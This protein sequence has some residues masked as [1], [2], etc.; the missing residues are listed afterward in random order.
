M[1]AFHS[2]KFPSGEDEA[3]TDQI[4]ALSSAGTEVSVVSSR[5]P[6][7]EL[8]K[9]YEQIGLAWRVVTGLGSQE[10]PRVIESTRPD[11]IHIH[12][13]F[14]VWG[15][16][17]IRQLDTPALVTLHNY[18]NTCANGSLFRDGNKCELCIGGL[19]VDAV[20]F[21]CFKGSRTQSALIALGNLRRKISPFWVKE[22]LMTI[23]LSQRART[24]HLRA[25][26]PEANNRVLSNFLA[27]TE[28]VTPSASGR[29]GWVFAG[30]L[31][32]GKGI[33]DLID[34]WPDSEKLVI[35]GDGPERDKLEKFAEGKDVE[36]RG[37][38]AWQ[39]VEQ[40][41]LE[42]E[43]M[44]FPSLF[45]ENFPMVYLRALRTG[46][47]TVSIE[48]NTVADEIRDN[49]SGVVVRGLDKLTFGMKQLR[50]RNDWDIIC[51]EIFD[52]KYSQDAWL[53][54][55][56]EILVELGVPV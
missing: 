56:V 27:D 1:H 11:W 46:T 13:L 12:N 33:R 17:W 30:R 8:L 50:N 16:Q 40:A 6:D 54:R 4:V 23:S 21:G 49:D 18:R 9:L 22:D 53:D 5:T 39:Q 55:Y 47:P 48:G 36:F 15:D 42:S 3:V 14:P 24:L 29:S 51:R 45:H 38:V 43:G 26:I 28:D 34:H 2:E 10:L 37:M 52:T 44:I 35:L 41:L 32:Q 25:G 19:G 20:R 31:E 7:K